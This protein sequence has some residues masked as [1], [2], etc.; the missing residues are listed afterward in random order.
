MAPLRRMILALVP[1]LAAV[2]LPAEPLPQTQAHG[3]C[4]VK[5]SMNFRG[6]SY[7]GAFLFARNVFTNT[8]SLDARIVAIQFDVHFGNS[9]SST[10]P[11][12]DPPLALPAGGEVEYDSP[13][14]VP[15]G[16]SPGAYLAKGQAWLQCYDSV[17]A[18]WI[19]PSS[20][21]LTTTS[22]LAISH[23]PRDLFSIV[24]VVGLVALGVVAVLVTVR[25]KRNK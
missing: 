20:A 18:T 19:M 14:H 9:A 1:L 5:Y 25:H 7:S 13:F 2:I 12:P 23:G 4:S 11:G 3:T 15:E 6:W 24:G 8:G 17:S 22:S 10:G 16:V 21:P